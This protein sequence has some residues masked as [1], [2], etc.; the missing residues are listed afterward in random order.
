MNTINTIHLLDELDLTEQLI[1]KASTI[2]W[3]TP[4]LSKILLAKRE[5]LFQT[6]DKLTRPYRKSLKEILAEKMAGS[7]EL[8]HLKTRAAATIGFEYGGEV[9]KCN[10]CLDIWRKLLRNLWKNY[11]GKREAMA[12]AAKRCGN[13][14]SYISSERGSLFKGKTSW[15][16]MKHS[17]ELMDGWYMDTNVTP[18]RIHKILPIVILAAGLKW[19][20]DVRVFWV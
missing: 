7:S 5:G 11:P 13:N 19:G 4:D 17:R 15:W 16:V 6:L 18:E 14:R 9:T 12:A 1:S 2:D 20:E 8:P 3:V 10:C